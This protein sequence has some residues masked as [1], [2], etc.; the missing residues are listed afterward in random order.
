MML[1]YHHHHCP[2]IVATQLLVPIQTSYNICS[3]ERTNTCIIPSRP[4]MPA[5]P[6]VPANPS[7]PPYHNLRPTPLP[8]RISI[9]L[10]IY[11]PHPIRDAP[12]VN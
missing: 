4:T 2:P 12:P 7:F 3:A 11:R 6:A 1:Q 5:R 8:Y 9:C 10:S